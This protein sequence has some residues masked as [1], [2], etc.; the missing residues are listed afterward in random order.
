MSVLV[1]AVRCNLIRLARISVE[2]GG[3]TVKGGVDG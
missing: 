2:L 1:L 3:R